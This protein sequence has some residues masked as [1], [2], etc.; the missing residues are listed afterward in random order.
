MAKTWQYQLQLGL[1]LSHKSKGSTNLKIN[2]KGLQ[3]TGVTRGKN[4]LNEKLKRYIP[5][6]PVPHVIRY[7]FWTKKVRRIVIN[8]SLLLKQSFFWSSRESPGTLAMHSGPTRSQHYRR[9]LSKSSLPVYMAHRSSRLIHT[10]KQLP[11]QSL[12]SWT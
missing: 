11:K 7:G 6:I 1:H 5:I 3:S 12:R 4:K 2:Q 9:S 10:E 8:T